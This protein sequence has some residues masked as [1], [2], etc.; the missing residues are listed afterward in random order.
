MLGR[1]SI[2]VRRT[3]I[4][5]FSRLWVIFIPIRRIFATWD[6]AKANAEQ[7]ELEAVPEIRGHLAT[8]TSQEENDVVF[9]LLT[10]TSWLGGSDDEVEGEWR[11][12][13]GPEAGQQFWQGLAGGTPVGGSYE[14]WAPGEPNQFFGPGNPENFAHLRADGLWN[15]LPRTE[16]LNYIIEWGG[17]L[18]VQ[19][20]GVNVSSAAMDYRDEYLE[21]LG[22]MDELAKDTHYRGIRLLEGDT[23]ETIFNAEQSSR[24]KIEGI[25]ATSKGL[26]F[27]SDNFISRTELTATLEEVQGAREKLRSFGS[28]LSVDISI[29]Q[30][31]ES[32]S[33]QSVISL[34]A[35]GDDLTVAD[36][37]QLGAELLAVQTRQAVQFQTLGLSAQIRSASARALFG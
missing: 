5:A 16:N 23:Y 30:I 3:A 10:A 21:V 34:A 19:N 20:A 4:R 11:W 12:V 14:N 13:T 37:N 8:I 36:Q 15:D 28:T 1:W 33:R 26:G 2:F 27:I 18:F 6:V 35:G 24:L 31:R 7:A 9:G 29:M 32:F 17:D 25:D 22:Q